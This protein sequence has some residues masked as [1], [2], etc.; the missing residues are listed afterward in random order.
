MIPALDVYLPATL[1]EDEGQGDVRVG[2]CRFGLKRG[3]VNCVFTYDRSYLQKRGAF[4]IDPG[5]PLN[6]ASHY[7]LGLPGALRDSS[8]DRW[9]RHLIARRQSHA[10]REHDTPLRTL[11]EVDYLIGVHDLARQ[12]ALRYAVPGASTMLSSEGEVPPIIELKRLLAASNGLILGGGSASQVK[13]LLDAGSGSLGGARPKATV[14][15]GGR[16][17]LAKFSHPGDEWNVMAWEKAVLDLAERAGISVPKS[18]LVHIGPDS[19]LVLERF[20]RQGSCLYGER[21]PYL[22]AMTLIGA[23]DGEQRDYVEVAEELAVFSAK[24]MQELRRL[25]AR[26]AFSVLMHNTDDHLRNLGLLYSNGSWGLSPL[27]DVNINP[28]IRRSRVTSIYGETGAGEVRA[29][30]EL[31]LSCRLDETMAREIIRNLLA[32]VAQVRTT[33]RKHG[34]PEREIM[35]MES[36]VQRKAAELAASFVI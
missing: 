27:F 8:P 4:S 2:D 16:L 6:A 11:D 31:A 10:A 15:D 9:G 7:C 1:F 24:P 30:Y 35:Q 23:Q 12:G 28:D 32:V 17:L 33:A 18:K 21:I 5:M 25:F 19:V 34:C 14:V 29:L 36:V 3:L 26:A 20:D 13:E 22:S